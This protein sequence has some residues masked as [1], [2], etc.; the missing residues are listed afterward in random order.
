MKLLPSTIIVLIL[1]FL[2]AQTQAGLITWTDAINSSSYTDVV[3]DGQLIEAVNATNSNNGSVNVNGVNFLNSNTLLDQQGFVGA[4][5]GTSSGDS[6]YNALLNSFDYGNGTN[7]MALLLGNNSLVSGNDYIIQVWYSDLR[8]KYSGRDMLFGDTNGNNVT[9]NASLGGLGQ[10]AL[11]RF[12]ATGNNQSLMLDAQG[13]QNAHISAYQIRQLGPTT[14]S[15]AH[16]VSAPSS[17]LIII[18]GALGL[19]YRRR[20]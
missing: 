10:F 4:L 16:A 6:G 11:G 19:L 9:L 15:Q 8:P 18:V 7:Q 3:L 17:L 12:S 20:R 5:N 2:S 14:T 1:S 13:F